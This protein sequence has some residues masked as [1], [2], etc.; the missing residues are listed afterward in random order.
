MIRYLSWA[1]F[2]FALTLGLGSTVD[3]SCAWEL[4]M[5]GNFSSTY[6]YYSQAGPNGF[7]GRANI[8]NSLGT[9][10]ALGLKPGDFASL[11]GWVGHRA[12]DLVSGTDS[13][14]HYPVLE[15]FPEIR[16]TQAV[17]FRGKYRLGDYGDPAAS[18]YITNNRPG[19]DTATS[20]GQWTM[21]WITAQTPWG[22]IALGKRPQIWGTG[23]Q[24]DGTLNSTTEGLLLAVN[25]GPLRLGLGFQPFWQ[26]PANNRVGL[27][28]SPYYNLFD[29]NGL[30]RL[31]TGSFVTCR[32]GPADFGARC[33]MFRWHAGPE[34]KNTQAARDAFVPYDD[35]VLHGSVYLKYFNGTV[36]FN[37]EAAYW[38]EYMNRIGAAPQYIDSV[39]FMLETGAVTGPVRFTMLYAFM[40]GSDRR[41]GKAIDRQPVRQSGPCG[42]AVVFKPYSFLLGYAYGSGVNAI[43]LCRN[44]YINEASVLAARVD[45]AVAANLNFFGSFLWA[46]RTSHGHTW[47]YIRPAQKATV[48][49]TVNAV[50]TGTDQATWTPYVNYKDNPNAP[51]IP[52][53]G[54]GWEITA[55]AQWKL[56]EKYRVD[57]LGAYWNP[58]KWFN[59]ACIDRGVAGWDVPAGGNSWG[60]NPGRTID[61][62]F[63]A[64]VILTADF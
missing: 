6:E 35:S 4:K 1:M 21:W 59:H 40:P 34:S 2:V 16:I 3:I 17:S 12:R 49:R 32:S 29:K 60:T 53:N 26:E 50:G 23:L 38:Y 64:Q 25:Y 28:A 5:D 44:G 39:R 22:I 63:G 55:G 43:D 51:T 61:P 48:T 37:T 62:I 9:A 7:F 8:D 27:S 58:G 15:V 19:V 24:Y 31:S 33:V 36:F 42:A 46:E 57:I 56:L 18:D 47:G 41:S 52:D 30:R 54:L 45:Y 13:S 14:Q 10:G 20:D 11:N